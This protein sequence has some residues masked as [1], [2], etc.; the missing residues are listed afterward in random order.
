V[1]PNHPAQPMLRT[2]MSLLQ[3]GRVPESIAAY[4]QI[5][6]RW[7]GLADA[8]YNLGYQLRL[9]GRYEDALAA[10]QRALDNGISR[11]EEILANRSAIYSEN[12]RRDDAAEAEL[13]KA[14]SLK[15]DYIPAL[16]N[17]AGLRE[18]SG[19]REE[20]RMLYGKVLTLDPSHGAALARYAGTQKAWT[21]D[22]P[23][24]PRLRTAAASAR[25][26]P[27]DR[28]SLLFALG[29]ALDAS[30]AFKEAFEAYAAANR[31]SAKLASASGIAYDRAK[32]ERLVDDLIAACPARRD[33]PP[34]GT[35]PKPI[36]ICG[37]FRSGST[38]AEQVLSAHPR[39]TAGGEL[40]IVPTLAL[41]EV[42]PFPAA[43]AHMSAE[44]CNRLAGQYLQAVRA[45]FPGADL[46]TDKRPDNFLYIG[47]IKAMF[48]D[49]RIVNTTRH[50]VDNA[51]S[52]FFL[53]LGHQFSYGF[54]LLDTAHFYRQYRRLM[55]HWR[56]LYPD[57]IF[58][59]DYDAFVQSPR[60]QTDA[61]LR[62]CDLEWDDAC[63]AFHANAGQVRTASAWQ[64][65]E[66]LH[67]RSSGRWKNYAQQ[68]APLREALGDLLPD[69]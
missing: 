69:T 59:F 68:L 64:V 26:A 41:R 27:A 30:G 50:P 47:L 63:L 28:A 43:L 65:R 67:S 25:T 9:V 20:A 29:Q 33:A 2:A 37:M 55:D 66:P 6:A 4:E 60:A 3:A 61:L 35:A 13:R 48:P 44:H 31:E 45:L 18:N 54:D 24:L 56:R 36:F 46:L 7:P 38:L 12:L 57:D 42:T 58:D 22:D 15:R 53:H 51:L 16:L 49:A 40:E 19:D 34:A 11:P 39:V 17:L 5:L 62:F 23:L 1:T 8:W 14:L 21:P 10:Y 52:V 32:M